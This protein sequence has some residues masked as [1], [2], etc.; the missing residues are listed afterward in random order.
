MEP[1][2][3]DRG[4]TDHVVVFDLETRRLASEVGGW[5]ALKRGEGGVSALVLY[6]NRTH[7]HHLY[8]AHTLDAGIRHLESADLVLSFNGLEFDL[9]V[10]AGLADRRIIAPNHLDLLQLVWKALGSRQGKN[11]LDAIGRRTLGYGK[12]G[13][14]AH[15][16]ALADEGRWAELFDYCVADVDLTRQLFKFVQN[17]GGVVSANG[18]LLR[19]DMPLGF[20]DLD[21]GL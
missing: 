13:D 21:L 3:T 20:E 18:D 16:P 5:D 17:H 1:V 8:D 19:L 4:A 6:D 14:G 7:R 9:R 12:T 10:L 2:T 15:A 11:T